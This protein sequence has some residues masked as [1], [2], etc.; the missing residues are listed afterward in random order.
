MLW[1]HHY[2]LLLGWGSHRLSASGEEGGA[3][4]TGPFVGGSYFFFQTPDSLTHSLTHSSPPCEVSV[5]VRC[6]RLPGKV[7]LH[8]S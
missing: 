5:S 1:E 3:Q 8:R 4:I 7:L 6:V 2:Y